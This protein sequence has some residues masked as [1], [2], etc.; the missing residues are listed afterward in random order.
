MCRKVLLPDPDGPITAV[1]EPLVEA[2]VEAVE[3][4]D[5]AL[6]GAVHLADALEP[7]GLLWRCG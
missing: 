3:G 5:R 7:H 1:N 4:D 2:D 6:A